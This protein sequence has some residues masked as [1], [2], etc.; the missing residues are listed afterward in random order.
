MARAN[1]N[2]RLVADA[3]ENAN[4]QAEAQNLPM[5]GALIVEHVKALCPAGGKGGDK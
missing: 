2:L 3:V 4:L 5:T 1:G